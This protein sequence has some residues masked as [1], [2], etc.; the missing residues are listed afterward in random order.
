VLDRAYAH[1]HISA[2]A[3][4]RIVKV[5]QTIADLAGA[6]TISVAHV[7]ESLAYR[8]HGDDAQST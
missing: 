1:L 5:A 3:C 4:D 8:F 2:R 6:P 7:A